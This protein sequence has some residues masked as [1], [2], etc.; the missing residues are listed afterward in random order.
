MPNIPVVRL[1]LGGQPSDYPQVVRVRVAGEVICDLEISLSPG[2][3]PVVLVTRADDDE[4]G[5]A[6]NGI[7]TGA[8]DRDGGIF[9]G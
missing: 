8:C 3:L 5:A 7:K 1:R 9:Q 4:P 6:A 2:L